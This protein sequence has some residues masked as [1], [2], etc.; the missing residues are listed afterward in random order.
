MLKRQLGAEGIGKLMHLFIP[1][2]IATMVPEFAAEDLPLD[3]TAT[4]VP[5]FAVEDLPLGTTL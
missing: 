2:K 4:L 3:R 1:R 5:A